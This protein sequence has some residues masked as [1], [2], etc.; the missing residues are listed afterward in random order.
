MTEGMKN[1]LIALRDNLA[2]QRQVMLADDLE[3]LA[4]LTK[5]QQ[6]LLDSLDQE[7]LLALFRRGDVAEAEAALVKEI[8]ELLQT[9][10]MLARQSLS[11]AK[12][13]LEALTGG[14]DGQVLPGIGL[15]KRV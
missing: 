10:E 1:V 15:D 5:A 14:A 13:M 6:E 9:N 12:R 8:A 4:E 3:S 7:E 11:F 2:R